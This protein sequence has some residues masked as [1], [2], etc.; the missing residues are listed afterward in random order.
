M[1]AAS[2]PRLTAGNASPAKKRKSRRR[3]E[4][5]TSPAKRVKV[6]GAESGKKS[7]KGKPKIRRESAACPT[8]PPA[9]V[10]V[11]RKLNLSVLDVD[12]TED[13]KG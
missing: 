1:G 5:L 2:A 7:A 13:I 10:K 8:P 12:T 11:K 3:S 6:N 9:K 4:L